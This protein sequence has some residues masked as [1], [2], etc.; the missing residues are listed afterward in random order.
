MTRK[1]ANQLAF[2]AGVR[3]ALQKRGFTKEAGFDPQQ[4]LDFLKKKEVMGAGIGAAGGGLLGSLL[5]HPLI[6]AGLGAA[7]GFGVGSYLNDEQKEEPWWQSQC[8]GK[9]NS[10]EGDSQRPKAWRGVVS[11]AQDAI[12]QLPYTGNMSDKDRNALLR[13]ALKRGRKG[14]WFM[15]WLTRQF[16]R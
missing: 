5:G 2:L 1:Q 4:I 11:D 7:G 3:V 16:I 6:G 14:N 15:N 8:G 9:M 10:P 12:N 13:E